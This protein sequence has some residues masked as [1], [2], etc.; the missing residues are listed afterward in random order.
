MKKIGEVAQQ[1]DISI[2]TLRY[3]EK[4]QLLDT[5]ERTD[6]GIR[7]YSDTDIANIQFI[8]QAQKMGFS[9]EEIGQLL[10]FRDSP[11]TAKPQVRQLALEKLAAIE[12]HITELVALRDELKALTE[13]CQQSQG[14]CPILE[15]FEGSKH[16]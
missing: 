16:Q 14:S 8:Q 13:Q 3:Y 5:I 7:L 2:D 1:L 12:S 4:I 9:L 10:Q 6:K 11:Q 15:K